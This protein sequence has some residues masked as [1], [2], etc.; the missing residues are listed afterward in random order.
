MIE[1]LLP[2]PGCS[3]RMRGV[4]PAGMQVTVERELLPA[5]VGMVPTS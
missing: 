4:V 1:L 2:G 5:S 3:P